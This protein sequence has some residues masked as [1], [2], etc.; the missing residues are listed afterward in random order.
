MLAKGFKNSRHK[1]RRSY[2]AFLDYLKYQGFLYL[3]DQRHVIILILHSSS[4]TKGSY[5]LI[6]SN[7]MIENL[8]F[9]MFI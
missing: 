3:S 7:L 5:V 6:T 2:A 1:K 9:K 4:L 8:I